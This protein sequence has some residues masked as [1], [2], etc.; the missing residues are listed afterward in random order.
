MDYGSYTSPRMVVWRWVIILST[1]ALV[2]FLGTNQE[3]L[4]WLM[5]RL[6]L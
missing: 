6:T 3:F 5:S 1:A 4:T 2:V